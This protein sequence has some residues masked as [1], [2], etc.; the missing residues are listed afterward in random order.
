[1]QSYGRID[2]LVPN[3]GMQFVAPVEDFPDERWNAIHD[4]LLRSPFL[5]ARHAWGAL[6][7]A[8]EGRVIPVA[9][10][11]GLVASPYKCAYVSAKHGLLGLVKTLALEGASD[12][13]LV[14]AVCPGFVHTPLVEAQ[15]DEQAT[16]HGLP[17]ERVL[18]EV[19]LA[20]HAVKRLIDPREV[21]S[22]VAYLAGPGG[23]AF[24][25]AAIPLDLGWTAS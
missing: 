1:M 8:P 12:E 15:I 17:R 16:A 10:V 6:R 20:P 4:V 7:A 9:S 19:I 13:I 25:G 23:S 2:V 11:H 14:N 22:F 18:D 21:A 3:A 5:L 24:S